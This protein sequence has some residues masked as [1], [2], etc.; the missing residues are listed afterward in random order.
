MHTTLDT[1][2]P[3]YN[4]STLSLE[5]KNKKQIYNF[6]ESSKSRMKR[7]E[8]PHVAPESYFGHPWCRAWTCMWNRH[9]QYH[10][11]IRSGKI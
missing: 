4:I 6:S 7:F 2:A 8:E 10:K 9:Y 5:I 1:E 11:Q 3:F